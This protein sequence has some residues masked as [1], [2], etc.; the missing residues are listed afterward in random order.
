MS[1]GHQADTP[2]V[3]IIIPHVWSNV[4]KFSVKS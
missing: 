4:S 1:N 2:S 3:L